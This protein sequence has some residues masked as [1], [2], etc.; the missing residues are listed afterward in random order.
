[1]TR[2]AIGGDDDL[3]VELVEIIKDIEEFFLRFLFADDKLE[4]IDDEDVEFAEFEIKFVAFADADGVDEVG[5]EMGDGGV[6]DFE[7]GVFS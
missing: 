6:E 3:F 5:I 2:E 7:G 4:I 1:M